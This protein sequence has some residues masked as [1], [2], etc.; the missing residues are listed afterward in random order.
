MTIGSFGILAYFSLSLLARRSGPIG[1]LRYLG[2]VLLQASCVLLKDAL[3]MWGVLPRF[4]AFLIYANFLYG[5]PALYAYCETLLGIAPA[6]PWLR[7]LPAMAN[8]PFAAAMGACGATTAFLDCRP[9]LNVACLPWLYLNLLAALET[10]Q[11][12]YYS[13]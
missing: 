6:R 4:E 3:A 13:R 12:V 7:F 8:V 11:L 5:L 2:I 1:Y 9:G 10:A